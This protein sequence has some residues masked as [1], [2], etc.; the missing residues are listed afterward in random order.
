MLADAWA[1]V[2]DLRPTSPRSRLRE[3]MI[4]WQPWSTASCLHSASPIP[5]LPPVTRMR[6]MV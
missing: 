4:T 2:I 3:P 1:S 5:A 6:F